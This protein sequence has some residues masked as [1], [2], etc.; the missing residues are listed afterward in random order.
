MCGA[1]SNSVKYCQTKARARIAELVD[2]GLADRLT[3]MV[4]ESERLLAKRDWER[5]EDLA[6]DAYVEADDAVDAQVDLVAEVEEVLA[7]PIATVEPTLHVEV[8]DQGKVSTAKQKQVQ[9]R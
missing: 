2:R 8:D 3:G 1:N 6:W 7:Q 4:Q 9:L 5:A